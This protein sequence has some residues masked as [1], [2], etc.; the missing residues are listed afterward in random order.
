MK[1]IFVL[2]LSVLF[3]IILFPA[4]AF[5]ADFGPEEWHQYRMNSDKNAVYENDWSASL[6]AVRKQTGKS[7]DEERELLRSNIKG[8]GKTGLD[9]FYRRV[10]WI[11]KEGY[12]FIDGRTKESSNPGIL[13]LVLPEEESSQR[14]GDNLFL[15]GYRTHY[16]S[17]YLQERNWL[18]VAA[19]NQPTDVEVDRFLEVFKWQF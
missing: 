2:M 17:S 13:T 3:V 7:V 6:E 5:A 9:I 16:E 4:K 15:N 14:L 10:Q 19:M 1:K 18:Q 12:P 11:W 8:L